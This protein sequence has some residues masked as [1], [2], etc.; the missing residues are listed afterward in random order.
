[1]KQI[2]I[3]IPVLFVFVSVLNIKAED[4]EIILSEC[5]FE[6]Q[7]SYQEWKT[8]DLDGK[9]LS[10]FHSGYTKAWFWKYE[11]NEAEAGNGVFAASSVFANNTPD[12]ITPADD[13]LFSPP[14]TVPETG[15]YSAVWDTRSLHDYFLDD[16]DVRVIEDDVLTGL[17]NGF[18]EETPLSE[19]SG[20]L[21]NHSDLLLEVRSEPQEWQN[22]QLSLN[23]YRGKI[24]RVIW[25]YISANIHTIYIDN[26]K[27]IKSTDTG[28][29]DIRQTT[30][31]MPV[32]VYNLHGLL[33]FRSTVRSEKEL[34]NVDLPTGVYLVKSDGKTWKLMR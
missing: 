1:M 6:T 14:L 30:P 2:K 8:Y 32:A 13:W 19:C 16:Y 15:N 22:H 17:E 31:E 28:I 24:I 27:Y 23:A 3:F 7:E 25:R 21:I 12:N 20:I 9:V 4:R 11:S 5:D 10:F 26:F 18:S 33:L 34:M 29:N